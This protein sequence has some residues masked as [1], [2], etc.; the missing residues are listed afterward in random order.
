VIV[1]V[2]GFQGSTYDMRNWKNNIKQLFPD[3]LILNS[4]KNEQSLTDGDIGAMG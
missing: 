4:S 2:H 1:L 3:A